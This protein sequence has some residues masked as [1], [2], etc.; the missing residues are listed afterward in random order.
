MIY[1][2]DHIFDFDLP[3]ALEKLSAQRRGQALR[4]RHELGQRTCAAAYLLMCEG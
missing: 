2:N 3:A 1:V 4:F